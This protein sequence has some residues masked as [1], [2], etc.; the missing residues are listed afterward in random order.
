MPEMN[1]E[2]TLH[3][4]RNGLHSIQKNIPVIALTGYTETDLKKTDYKFSGFLIKPIELD[5]L[6]K[7]INEV[8]N[9]RRPA[10]YR[11][12]ACILILSKFLAAS[13]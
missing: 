11:C 2:E 12:S 4:I 1:G 6:D 8:M 13:S 5:D 7:K 3:L 10:V 9:S